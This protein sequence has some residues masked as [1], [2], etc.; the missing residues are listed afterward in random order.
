MLKIWYN[1]SI[2]KNIV[3]IV[4]NCWGRLTKKSKKLTWNQW[5]F[6]L[7]L[8]KGCKSISTDALN[9]ITGIPHI[10]LSIEYEYNR[11]WILHFYT[12]KH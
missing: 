10:T 11:S 3:Y 6:L 4:G 5:A 7:Q 8:S 9:E 12:C 1:T 2:E